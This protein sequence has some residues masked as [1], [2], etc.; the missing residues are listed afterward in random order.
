MITFGEPRKTWIELGTD[1][2]FANED[3]QRGL[4]FI[5]QLIE[6]EDEDSIPLRVNPDESVVA[7]LDEDALL[8]LLGRHEG[9]AYEAF[10]YAEERERD[11][12]AW[13]QHNVP[14]ELL[15]TYTIK[16][17]TTNRTYFFS[18]VY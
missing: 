10:N 2:K 1:G 11:T 15:G 7:V 5:W 13:V 18:E 12:G 9:D 16:S 17:Y 4:D 8:G 3:H 6:Q 14:Y